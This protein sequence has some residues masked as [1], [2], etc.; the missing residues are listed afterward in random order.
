VLIDSSSASFF[1]EMIFPNIR[2]KIVI[3]IT[4]VITSSVIRGILDVNGMLRKRRIVISPRGMNNTNGIAGI[5]RISF[6][7]SSRSKNINIVTDK[8]VRILFMLNNPLIWV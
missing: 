7:K 8:A 1:L 5:F 4:S 2:I 3:K 6:M